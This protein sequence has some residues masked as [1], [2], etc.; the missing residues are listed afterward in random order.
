MSASTGRVYL[1]SFYSLEVTL[2]VNYLP[3][4][5]V[6]LVPYPFSLLTQREVLLM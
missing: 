2:M 1:M 4:A 5:P 3:W 6:G